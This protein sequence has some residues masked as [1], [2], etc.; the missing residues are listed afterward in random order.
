ML[1]ALLVAGPYFGAGAYFVRPSESVADRSAALSLELGYQ[2][3]HALASLTAL[4]T[5]G[6]GNMNTTLVA[7]KGAWII[8]D[9]PVA[10]FIGIGVGV[11]AQSL[12]CDPVRGCDGFSKSAAGSVAEAGVLLFRHA[13][14][15]VQLIGP[16]ER[17]QPAIFPAVEATPIPLL[18]IGFRVLG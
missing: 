8:T 16:F 12:H 2:W 3:K 14:A 6:T 18:L 5:I 7:V 1:L 11:F 17:V 15:S 13:I 9:T 10:P 4:G